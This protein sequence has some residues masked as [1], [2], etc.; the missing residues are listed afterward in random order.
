MFSILKRLKKAE[1]KWE[2]KTLIVGGLYE[3]VFL[4]RHPKFKY[5]FV[6]EPERLDIDN[7]KRKTTSPY[8][9]TPYYFLILSLSEIKKL[10][11]D[12]GSAVFIDVGC[13][14]GRALYCSS[15]FGFNHLIGIEHSRRLSEICN[16]NLKRYLPS[17]VKTKIVNSDIRDVDFLELIG[18]MNNR[19]GIRNLIFFLFTP[20]KDSVLEVFLDKVNLISNSFNCYIVYF[21]PQNERM[22]VEKGFMLSHADYFNKDTPIKIYRRLRE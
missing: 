15:T 9:P 3:V 18:Y 4:I 11:G 12:V 1:N 13:G 19:I 22:I 20:F 2:L 6:V 10:V 14:T 21:G 5:L 16:E 17:N 8:I 7:E